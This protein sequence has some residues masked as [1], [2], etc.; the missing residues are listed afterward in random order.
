MPGGDLVVPLFVVPT[1]GFGVE[2]KDKNLEGHI[3]RDDWKFCSHETWRGWFNKS[4]EIT[5]RA[6]MTMSLLSVVE[7][8]W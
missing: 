1:F 6:V 2:S 5:Q 8:G 3:K 7:R 4:L